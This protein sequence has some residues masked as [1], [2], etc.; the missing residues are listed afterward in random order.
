MSNNWAFKDLPNTM[1]LTTKDVLTMKKPILFTR[2]N[3]ESSLHGI[4]G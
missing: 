3:P 1:A 2:K 4:E